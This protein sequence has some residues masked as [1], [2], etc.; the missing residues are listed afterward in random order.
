MCEVRGEE[1]SNKRERELWIDIAKAM[2]IGLVMAGHTG[3]PIYLRSW[4]YLFHMPMFF[5]I[6][7]LWIREDSTFIKNIQRK[8]KAYII[9]YFGY[10]IILSILKFLVDFN[11]DN[12]VK[13]VYMTITGH[14]SFSILWFLFALFWTDILYNGLF[15]ILNKNKK[16][17][18]LCSLLMAVCASISNYYKIPNTLLWQSIFESLFFYS[19]GGGA[20]GEA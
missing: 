19:L 1:V 4:I 20:K 15:H 14:G 6:S 12:I 18:C 3:L 8:F 9:P 7:G 2:G 17:V 10:S 11:I 5:F 16:I 13:D